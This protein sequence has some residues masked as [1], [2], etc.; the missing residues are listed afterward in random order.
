MLECIIS[1]GQTGADQG[2]LLAARKSGIQ[3]GGWCPLGWRTELGPAP[4]LA[5]LKEPPLPDLDLVLSH[6][7]WPQAH[8]KS[9][10]GPA[11]MDGIGPT[12]GWETY[13][14]EVDVKRRREAPWAAS[15][16][17]EIATSHLTAAE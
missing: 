1:G 7:V 5:V 17:V 10:Q 13:W 16:P 12:K 8:A 9:I 4:W 3:T 14:M 11:T 6:E 15:V 2:G